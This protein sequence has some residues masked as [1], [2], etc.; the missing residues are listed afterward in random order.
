M[1][2]ALSESHSTQ[3]RCS[4]CGSETEILSDC[5][6]DRFANLCWNCWNERAH[7]YILEIEPLVIA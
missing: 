1:M 3:R 5:E 7:E 4:G 6:D 2:A